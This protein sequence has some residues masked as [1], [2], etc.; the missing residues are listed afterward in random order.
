VLK[1]DDFFRDQ[2]RKM[3]ATGERQNLG[4][5]MWALIGEVRCP[6]LSMRG[7]RSD[8]YAPATAAKMQA[9]NPRLRVA[10]VEAGHNIATEN[11]DGFL[12]EM[13]QFLASVEKSHEHARH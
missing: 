8:M 13:R 6:I 9:A 1:R 4:V 3:L 12:K 5:D 11:K 2:F 10:E 7:T